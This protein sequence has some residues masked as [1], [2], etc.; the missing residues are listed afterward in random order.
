MT[1]RVPVSE[2]ATQVRGVTY[3]ASE[4]STTPR[5][6]M[7]GV[8][9][10]G[11]IVEGELDNND[12]VYVPAARVS[13]KQWLK[14]GDVLIATSSGSLDVVGK[15]ARIRSD[16]DVA[17]G[18]FCKVLRPTAEVDAGY[19]AHFFQ[20]MPYR[21]HVARVAAGSNINNLKGRDLDNIEIL[22]PPI[23]EQRRIAVV[24]D[25]A[26]AIRTKRRQALALLDTLTQAVFHDILGDP[27]QNEHGW[28]TV[29]LGDVAQF[30]RGITFKPKDVVSAGEPGSVVCL[31]TKNVQ[32]EV[33]LDDLIAVASTF[34]KRQGQYLQAGDVLISSAN[35][36]NLV[37]KCCWIP[38][39]PWRASFGGFVTAS[40]P[41]TES[42]HRRYLFE[43][44]RH[45]R[46]QQLL[47]SFSRKTT[48]ISN[49][50]LDRC[51]SMAFPLPPVESQRQF[52]DAVERI[53]LHR[54]SLEESSLTL[55][56]LFASL[57]QRAFRGEL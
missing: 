30:V 56:T 50:N 31:R 52:V 48:N 41:T 10:A 42:V 39:L 55:D 12:L 33:D 19:F 8:V 53:Q 51:R 34:V 13:E 29:L 21:R 14:R 24:L 11:N 2:L 6:G 17:F 45:Q 54:T 18:A 15:A 32:A 16:Q 37:G 7:V 26:E 22:L 4:S 3:K 5:S 23:E 28:P 57:Q 35:S 20:T 36:W 47:R 40:R 9:R 25:A 27:V 38:E 1:A 46:I 43:W 49:L 44:L